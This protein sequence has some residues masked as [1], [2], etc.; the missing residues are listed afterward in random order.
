MKITFLNLLLIISIASCAQ[1]TSIKVNSLG[2]RPNDAKIAS[3][4]QPAAS[5]FSIVYNQTQ[6]IVIEGNIN[7]PVYQSDVNEKVARINFT[8]LKQPGKYYIKVGD[9][10]SSVFEIS[11]DVYKSSLYTSMR[12]MYLWRCGEAVEGEHNGQMYKHAACHT[13]DGYIA[14]ED[15]KEQKKDGVGGWHDAGDYGKYTVNAGVTVGALFLTWEHFNDKLSNLDL[16]LPSDESNAHFPDFLKEIKYEIDWLFKMQYTDGSGR[17]SHKLT[18]KNFSGFIMPEEDNE[19]RYFTTWSSAATADFVAMMAMASRN[20]RQYDETYADSCL[21]AAKVSYQ[22]LLEHPMHVKFEQGEFSTGGYQTDDSDDRL[23]AASEMWLAT[24]EKQY[25]D[26]FEQRLSAIENPVEL[27]WDWGNVG[28]L[29]VFGYVLH[30]DEAQNEE[31]YRKV[32][33]AVISIADAI[34]SNTQ[35][36]VYGRPMDKYFWGCNGTVARQSINLSVA[37]LLKP[38]KKY[39]D[40]TVSIVGHLFGC[41][42]YGRS[43]VTG[44]GVNPPMFPHSRR[45]AADSIEAPWPGYIVGGGHTATDWVDKEASYSHNEI[46]INWQAGLVYLLASVN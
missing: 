31:L 3:V 9:V 25:L 8:K 41:N 40:A 15:G 17:V 32:K 16:Q 22:C 44:L 46:A 20:F 13:D 21:A 10:K 39:I 4:T 43:F 19:K 38:D 26:D 14:Y 5:T 34:V 23:W 11:E 1:K 42:Y 6:E 18:R 36:D 45:S 27:N 35:Q 33:E 7:Q 29:G 24:G 37:N 28:N 2:F 30:A 12:A